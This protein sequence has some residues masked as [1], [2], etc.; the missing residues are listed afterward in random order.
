M[1]L[2]LAVRGGTVVDGTGAPGRRGDVGVRD[3]RIVEVGEVDGPAETELDAS[4]CVVAPGFIDPHTHLDAQLCWDGAATPT[5]LHGVTSVVIGLCGFGVAPCPP[6][7]GDY[8]LRSLER[9]EEIPFESTSAGVDFGWETWGEYLHHLATLPLAVNVA[10]LVPHSALRWYVMGERARGEVAT[11]DDR[12]AMVAELRRSLDG[13]ALGLA[14]SRGPNHEDGFGDPVPSRFADDDEIADLVGACRGRMWQ[15]N[16]ET[17]FSGDPAGL[18]S[19]IDRYAAWTDEAGARLSWTPLHANPDDG[20]WQAVLADNRERNR[21]GSVVYPQV[22]SQAVTILLRFDER[23]LLGLVPGWREAFAGYRELDDD[24]RLAHLADPP[25][26]E[27]MRAAPRTA[28]MFS[29]D[30]DQWVFLGSPS[31]PT[32]VGRT[33]EDAAAERGAHPADLLADTAVA[34]RLATQVQIPAVNRDHDAI[35]ALIADEHTLLGLGDSGAHVQSICGYSYPT[36][37]LSVLVREQGTVGLELAIE[38]MTRRPAWFCGL[39]DR[40][41]VRVGAAADL[42]VFDPERIALG[43]IRLTDDLPAGATRLHQPAVGYRAVVVGGTVVL[44]D[45]APTGAA[46]GRVI[47]AA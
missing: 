11:E 31:D 36:H 14:S 30:Y 47:G 7:G 27:A 37:V 2:D 21:A 32:L 22:A 10:G 26:R 1:A 34:D 5:N 28:E 35:P 4:G 42:T 6:D 43:E 46:A 33:V 18:I 41:T 9:V 39:G 19:E 15:I 17:K 20:V 38:R 29:P 8:L 40:G 24:G 25:V 23:S 3:G 44:A 12:A 13:G 16:V 45:D